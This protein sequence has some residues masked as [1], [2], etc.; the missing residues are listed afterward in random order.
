MVNSATEDEVHP[1]K[2]HPK[3]TALSPSREPL[4]KPTRSV[5]PSPGNRI[6]SRSPFRSLSPFGHHLDDGSHSR[7]QKPNVLVCHQSARAIV[8]R[9]HLRLARKIIQEE[10]ELE[11]ELESG[12]ESED[13]ESDAALAEAAFQNMR[14]TRQSTKASIR[15]SSR[16]NTSNKESASIVHEINELARSLVPE[17]KNTQFE[18]PQV[19]ERNLE[20][21]GLHAHITPLEE[22]EYT[23]TSEFDAV[24]ES[25][26]PAS[27]WTT[28]ELEVFEML[29][30]QKACVKTIKNSEWPSF[31]KRFLAP[32]PQHV[33]RHAPSQHDDIGPRSGF[34]FNS[35]VTSTSLLPE[36]GKKMRCYGS[37]HAYTVGVVFALPDMDEAFEEEAQNETETWSWP[38]GYAA[39]VRALIWQV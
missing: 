9:D 25:K 20:I 5:S 31:L 29:Q 24:L 13:N 30:H 35:F 28:A 18:L 39:K 26:E 10:D 16:T 36:G 4:E 19:S 37:N 7:N 1:S 33:F 34:P 2:L 38:A 15:D 27:D 32:K 23:S 11:S 21:E 8:F 14:S 17:F 12:N 22:L 6:R 3:S